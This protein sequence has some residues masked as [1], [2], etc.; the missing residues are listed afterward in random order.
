MLA[1]G[2]P[3][4]AFDKA[5]GEQMRELAP[6]LAVQ[7]NGEDLVCPHSFGTA[8]DVHVSEAAPVAGPL[9]ASFAA[10]T[11]ECGPGPNTQRRRRPLGQIC[12]GWLDIPRCGGHIGKAVAF[13]RPLDCS[14]SAEGVRRAARGR[15]DPDL[16]DLSGAT[17]TVG[18][19]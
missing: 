10:P 17:A 8:P 9:R 15:N 7:R 16:R 13:R 19:D 11:I 1:I 4:D 3:E 5:A 14:P 18:G 6:L 2:R 12:R